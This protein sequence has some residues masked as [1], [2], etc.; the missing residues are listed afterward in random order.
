MAKQNQTKTKPDSN[1]EHCLCGSGKLRKRCCQPLLDGIAFAKTPVQLMR[2][3][4]SA[5]ALGGYG[6]YLFNTWLPIKR[7]GLSVHE[8]S[9]RTTHWSRLQVLSK[10][11]KGNDGFVEFNAL[12]LDDDLNEH[13]HYEHSAFQRVKGRW[14]Y[15]GVV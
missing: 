1:K 6:D 13:C 11:Q 10:A 5:Y 3:R 9:L 15:V 2:S 12:Y 4:Y 8:L 7:A 14:F